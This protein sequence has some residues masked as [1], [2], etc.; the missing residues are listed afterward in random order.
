MFT[1]VL[2]E[3]GAGALLESPVGRLSAGSRVVQEDL[4]RQKGDGLPGVR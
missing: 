4:F 3:A 2:A 1:T